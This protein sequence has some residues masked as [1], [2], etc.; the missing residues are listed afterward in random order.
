MSPV[1]SALAIVRCVAVAVERSSF[2][3]NFL[4]NSNGGGKLRAAGLDQKEAP[5]QDQMSWEL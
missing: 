5:P 4:S 3:T 2:E 1:A